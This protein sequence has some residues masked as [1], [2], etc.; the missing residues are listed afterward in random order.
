VAV[1]EAGL[2]VPEAAGA[3]LQL[4]LVT[5][6]NHVA[7]DTGTVAP[8]RVQG[9][10]LLVALVA[11]VE[12][13]LPTDGATVGPGGF[14]SMEEIAA[15]VV[16][17]MC[18]MASDDNTSGDDVEEE[19][20]DD[21]GEDTAMWT[22]YSAVM[23]LAQLPHIAPII[24]APLLGFAAVALG[25]SHPTA[26]VAAAKRAALSLIGAAAAGS[27]L[28]VYSGAEQV[29]E[30]LAAAARDDTVSVRLAAVVAVAAVME[31]GAVPEAAV[32]GY[33]SMVQAALHDPAT[34]VQLGG[35][36][37]VD[38]LFAAAGSNGA[39]NLE[40]LRLL[41][42][43]LLPVIGGPPTQEQPPSVRCAA[44]DAAAQ[45]AVASC[46][47]MAPF[48]PA[49]CRGTWARV[50]VDQFRQLAPQ[51][52]Q[53][54]RAFSNISRQVIAA[55][56][57]IVLAGPSGPSAAEWPLS[58]GVLTSLLENRGWSEP[59]AVMQGVM[60]QAASAALQLLCGN[61]Q[62]AGAPGT[63]TEVGG[64]APDR[65]SPKFMWLASLG[66]T[67]GILCDF[68]CSILLLNAILG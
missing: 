45:L 30:A 27:R 54:H 59:E 49:V 8:T 10:R 15:V 12:L 64:R 1:A 46:E 47:Q 34:A 44:M 52:F 29:F 58:C 22:S 6:S 28:A 42:C 21:M 16:G 43:E 41:I 3:L 36:K 19:V 20:L 68:R 26:E 48:A 67:F 32:E 57:P 51:T 25:S 35:F 9:A 11:G 23:E 2:L 63:L 50:T 60:H 13:L 7:T 56:L 4:A 55:I 40:L 33:V 14:H 61:L 31:A 53:K 17:V 65:A 18:Q 37:A 5:C 62:P 38:V 39:A 66:L 24:L